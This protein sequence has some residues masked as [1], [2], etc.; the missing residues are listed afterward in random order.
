MHPF[1]RMGQPL[2]R[3][4]QSLRPLGAGVPA[5]PSGGRPRGAGLTGP[6]G[7]GGYST[8]MLGSVLRPAELMTTARPATS[9]P[10]AGS[11]SSDGT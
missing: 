9:S 11:A 4:L 8:G 10:A 1:V 3:P 2:L 6:A 5:S 7:E